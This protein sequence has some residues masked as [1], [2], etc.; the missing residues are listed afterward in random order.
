[1]D[2]KSLPT[3]FDVQKNISF[4]V[5]NTPIPFEV[6]KLNIGG[7]MDRST[8]IFTA[9]RAGKYFFSFSGIAFF[10]SSSSLVHLNFGLYVNSVLV[11]KGYA[12]E[13]NIN[14]LEYEPCVLQSAVH[15]QA[16]D[17]VWIQIWELSSGSYLNGGLYPHFTGWLLEEDI[18]QSLNVL[19]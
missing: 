12:D 10:P 4:N 1:M 14:G 13:T 2:V 5:P 17:K 16:G 11:A 19:Y 18:F 15:L 3:Y 7:A 9:P 8:G 6:E